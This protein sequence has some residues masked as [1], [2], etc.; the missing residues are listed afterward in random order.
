MVCIDMCE[1]RRDVKPLPS[2]MCDGQ[3]IRQSRHPHEKE[4]SE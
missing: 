2:E 4:D 1:G 3:F